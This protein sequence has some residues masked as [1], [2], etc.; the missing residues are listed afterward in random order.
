LQELRA[1]Q[2]HDPSNGLPLADIITTFDGNVSLDCATFH[3][4]A[5][6]S[7]V[8]SDNL[9]HAASDNSATPLVWH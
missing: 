5:K 2:T 9:P 1:R 6:V 3:E 7:Q 4:V 8:Q